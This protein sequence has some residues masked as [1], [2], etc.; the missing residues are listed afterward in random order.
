M[1]FPLADTSELWN[2]LELSN[3]IGGNIEIFFPNLKSRSRLDQ[4]KATLPGDSSFAS[5]SV[6]FQSNLSHT[7][8]RFVV[9]TVC[10]YVAK[11][12]NTERDLRVD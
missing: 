11:W 7:E 1:I 10:S 5:S 12:R 4:P 6:T 2:Y 9:N 3:S 8:A